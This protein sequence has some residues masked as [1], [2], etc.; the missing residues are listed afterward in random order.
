MGLSIAQALLRRPRR[1]DAAFKSYA[2][3]ERPIKEALA[4]VDYDQIWIP[5]A[6][7]TSRGASAGTLGRGSARPA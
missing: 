6:S 4:G 3:T 1:G 7:R 2:G 5:T